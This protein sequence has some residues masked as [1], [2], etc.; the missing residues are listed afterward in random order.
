MTEEIERKRLQAY[1]SQYDNKDDDF[2]PM[3]IIVENSEGGGN[4]PDE[5][6]IFES[7]LEWLESDNDNDIW[8]HLAEQEY[9]NDFTLDDSEEL[10]YVVF[11]HWF[12]DW[13]DK[14]DWRRTFGDVYGNH[15]GYAVL[16]AESSEGK[17]AW[18]FNRFYISNRWKKGSNNYGKLW[19]PRSCFSVYRVSGTPR[20][21]DMERIRAKDALPDGVNRLEAEEEDYD[22]RLALG[23]AL[24]RANNEENQ[25]LEK[26]LERVDELP[27]SVRPRVDIA[28]DEYHRQKSAEKEEVC[29]DELAMIINSITVALEPGAVAKYQSENDE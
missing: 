5:T 13:D 6:E 22:W 2:E 25:P 19:G 29:E 27:E 15:T 10:V 26:A 1:A 18:A 16:D 8:N 12:L 20:P 23:A 14:D 7:R 24:R 17:D 21:V 3:G 9:K 11:P 4:I 28:V